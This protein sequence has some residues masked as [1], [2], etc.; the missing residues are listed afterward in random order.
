MEGVGG[1][2]RH[3]G[4]GGPAVSGGGGAM[5][6]LGLGFV[7]FWGRMGIR[8]VGNGSLFA[9]ATHAGHRAPEGPDRQLTQALSASFHSSLICHLVRWIVLIRF[10]T[11]PAIRSVINGK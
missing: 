2:A 5:L 9:R 8:C 4:G 3:G 7:I 6:R 10:V 11:L 1:G